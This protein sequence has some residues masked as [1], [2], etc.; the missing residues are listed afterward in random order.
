MSKVLV[1]RSVED[2]ARLPV[3]TPPMRHLMLL[4]VCGMPLLT[5]CTLG[6]MSLQN[7]RL[8]YNR[9]I[10][11][12][13]REELLLN[14]VR[15][16]Y[17]ESEEFLGVSS[18]TG[19]YTYDA[20][21]RG[22]GAWPASGRSSYGGS[23]GLGAQS[24]PTI[25]YAPEQGSDF[26]QRKLSPV[27]LETLDLLASKGWALD[28]VFRV[29]V[30][31]I[32]DVDNATNAGGPTPATKPDFEEFQYLAGL[33]RSLQLD[34][35][36]VEV[37]QEQQVTVAGSKLNDAIPLEKIQ[38]D[39]EDVVLAANNGYQFR[40]SDDGA[41]AELWSRDK[42][43][44]VPILRFYESPLNT[45]TVNEI[46][47]ILNLAPKNSSY[48]IT[49]D[50]EGQLKSPNPRR[51]SGLVTLESGGDISA[52]PEKLT[53]TRESLTVSTR[54]LKEM[55]FYL[56]HAVCVP[57][58]HY[59]AGLVGTTYDASGQ[60][61]DW[62]NL[63]RGLFHVCVSKKKPGDAAVS[64]ERHGYWYYIRDNDLD[65]KSTFNLLLELINLEIRAGGGTHIPLLTI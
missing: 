38:L 37:A 52:V 48:R 42:V 45:E 60:P 1:S 43:A 3:W 47:S 57:Q 10:Q 61:F 36:S 49:L 24:K 18:I 65:S 25:V 12:T 59:N 33:L 14:L 35:H 4:L 11:H 62:N 13:S 55:M 31:N 26:N 27:S 29:V 16:R 32:N 41:S 30:R 40:L 15:M 64:V 9:A 22:T 17:Y 21:L 28:R 5:G 20:D 2:C 58:E 39:G 8:N 46:R 7:S 56:S 54:S 23:L 53:A 51:T 34:Q 50:N 19:Q 44:I 6:P 63:T